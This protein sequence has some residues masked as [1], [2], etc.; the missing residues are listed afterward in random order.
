VKSYQLYRQLQPAIRKFPKP[1]RYSLGEKL[2]T[3]LLNIIETSMQALEARQP[4]KE[5]Y[6][7]KVLGY[8]KSIQIFIR[9]SFDENLIDERHYFA[10][11]ETTVELLKMAK[12]W[13]KSTRCK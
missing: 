11:S 5:P 6:I 10:W 7:L 1:W 4:L 9:L 8:I 13:L 12:G 2:Q 3:G